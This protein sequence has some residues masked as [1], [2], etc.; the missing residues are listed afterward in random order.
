MKEQLRLELL[1]FAG[2]HWSFDVDVSKPWP[3]GRD[4]KDD[5]GLP[6]R[7]CHGN[8]GSR[9][10][11]RSVTLSGRNRGRIGAL[12][13]GSGPSSGAHLNGRRERSDDAQSRR[14]CPDGSGIR[15]LLYSITCP[16]RSRCD[17]RSVASRFETTCNGTC[18]APFQL[19]RASALPVRA[20]VPFC[21]PGTRLSSV[22]AING[23]QGGPQHPEPAGSRI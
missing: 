9:D 19:G 4:P 17:G 21:A 13:H 15:H 22:R 18:V 3:G 20:D 2:R 7:H 16:S 12:L 1:G 23:A 5:R 10:G 8:S 11:G 6:G 14:T